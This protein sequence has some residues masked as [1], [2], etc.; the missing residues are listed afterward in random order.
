[1]RVVPLVGVNDQGNQN[2]DVQDAG[3]H[4]VQDEGV[5]IVA[6]EEVEAT[7]ADKPKGTRKKRKTT[8]GASGSV[9]PPKRLREDHNTSG[10]AGASITEK[11]LVVLQD[12]L[13]SSPLAAEVGVTAAVNVIFVTSSVTPTP[14]RE[15]GGRTDYIFGPNLRTQHPAKRF[16]ISSD[17]SHHSSPNVADDEVT[18]IVRYQTGSALHF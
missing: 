16:V 8:G 9:L 17:Y 5:N 13:D 10:D 3:T 1:G 14:K 15:S 18:S 6:D 7:D 11:Y 4:V 2:D 12:L